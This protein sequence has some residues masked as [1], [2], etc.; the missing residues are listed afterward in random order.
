LDHLTETKGFSLK[1]IKYLVCI[2]FS[3]LSKKSQGV[4]CKFLARYFLR[5]E[6]DVVLA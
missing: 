1:K 4:C 5:L 2:H 3:Y 6:T